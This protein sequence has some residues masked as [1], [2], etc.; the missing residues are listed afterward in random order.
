MVPRS[1]WSAAGWLWIAWY[2]VTIE[3]LA[4]CN[5]WLVDVVK[6]KYGRL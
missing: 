4:R 2:T 3:T 1:D 5:S 6:E